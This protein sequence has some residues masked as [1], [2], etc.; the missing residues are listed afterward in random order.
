M[1]LFSGIFFVLYFSEKHVCVNYER[2][3]QKGKRNTW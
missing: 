2:I 3:Y 1:P